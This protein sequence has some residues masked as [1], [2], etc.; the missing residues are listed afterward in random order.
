MF[1]TAVGKFLFFIH[2]VLLPQ[3][4]VPIH[5]IIKLIFYNI[6]IFIC[7][8]ATEMNKTE[9]SVSISELLNNFIDP[10]M[11]FIALYTLLLL[12]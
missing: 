7:S 6:F 9:I 11:L 3:G 2:D 4:N 8:L 1:N 5:Q 10:S 12:I